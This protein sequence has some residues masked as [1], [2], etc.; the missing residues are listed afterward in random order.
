ML[1]DF[2]IEDFCLCAIHGN[3]PSYKMAF[4]LNKHI[5]LRLE[6]TSKDVEVKGANGLENYPKYVYE[7]ETHYTIYTLIKNKCEVTTNR[8][9]KS[10]LF[11]GLETSLSLKKLIPEYKNVDYFLK[12]ETENS[13]YP[14]KVLVAKILEIKQVITAYSVDYNNIKKKTNLIFE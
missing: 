14:M 10:N 1:N 13:Y 5:G 8:V 11:T 12:I 9:N 7:N 4:L 6:R 3:I 2:D